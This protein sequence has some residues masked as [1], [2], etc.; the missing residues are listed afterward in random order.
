ME[1][2]GVGCAG[3]FD[4][5]RGFVGNYRHC[6]LG[7]HGPLEGGKTHEHHL[8]EIAEHGGVARGDALAREQAED[9]ADRFVDVI[10]RIQTGVGRDDLVAGVRGVFLRMLALPMVEAEGGVGGDA[11]HR[12]ATAVGGDEGTTVR[13]FGNGSHGKPFG[14][15]WEM[16]GNA[17]PHPPCFCI[18]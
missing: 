10:E 12:A 7:L 1:T 15:N 3:F 2:V 9:I 13:I 5:V 17:P 8:A 6:H 18:C 14:V 4:L 11:V 16:R